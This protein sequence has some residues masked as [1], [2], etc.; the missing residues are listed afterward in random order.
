MIRLELSRYI[1][2]DLDNIADYIAQ[3]NPRRAVTFIQDIRTKI[4]DI[5]RNPLIYQFR[6]GIGVEAR[7]VTVGNDAILFRLMG[8]VIRIEGIVYGGRDLPNIFEL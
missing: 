2:G 4:F 8:E 3:N 5:Q 1:E 7:M 6:P